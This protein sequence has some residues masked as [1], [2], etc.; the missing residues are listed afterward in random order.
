MTI[1]ARMLAA[2]IPLPRKVHPVTGHA[3]TRAEW[4]YEPSPAYEAAAGALLPAGWTLYSKLDAGKPFAAR[5]FGARRE[6]GQA[7]V[8]GVR[9]DDGSPKMLQAAVPGAPSYRSRFA[10]FAPGDLAAAVTWCEQILAARTAQ[11]TLYR[12]AGASCP[13]LPYRASDL[14]H[15][16]SC[17]APR[18][19]S[20]PVGIAEKR[21]PAAQAK[22]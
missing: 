14:A 15:P 5:D 6:D 19:S 11:P 17:A 18:G 21:T 8:H 3:L 12:C 22:T 7:T 4:I 1:A 10:D 20:K 9:H 2:L 16:S 13:G